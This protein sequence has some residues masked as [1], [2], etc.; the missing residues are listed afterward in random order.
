[1][2]LAPRTRLGTT[3]LLPSLLM[4]HDVVHIDRVRRG[5]SAA[6]IGGLIM[7]ACAWAVGTETAVGAQPGHTGWTVSLVAGSL[8]GG[9]LEPG[10]RE[11]TYGGAVGLG[12]SHG[13]S[14]EA[15]VAV[16]PELRQFGHIELLLGSGSLLYHPFSVGRLTPYGLLGASLARLSGGPAGAEAEVELAVDVGG[17]IWLRVAGP[18][19]LRTDVRFIHI[20]DAPNFWR[21]VA[22][23]TVAP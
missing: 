19:A 9:D 5:R 8:F 14:L 16:I 1:M 12:A 22:G 3:T 2:S 18:I 13:L 17:G 10:E 23:I 20:D 15:E 7:L 21:A 4:G 6:R 11:A